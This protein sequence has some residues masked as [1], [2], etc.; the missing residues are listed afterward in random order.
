[1]G[2]SVFEFGHYDP[3]LQREICV[4]NQNIMANSVDH[5]EMARY[6][7][8]HLAPHCLQRSAVVCRAE[9]VKS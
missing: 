7:P 6:E 4:K 8:S 1:M 5:D 3:L 9:R 2:S